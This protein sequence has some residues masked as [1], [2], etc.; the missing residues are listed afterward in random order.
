MM[1]WAV[2]GTVSVAVVL[3]CAPA[4]A[5][6]GT[7]CVVDVHDPAA[8]YEGSH[9]DTAVKFTVTASAGCGG[10]VGY[11]TLHDQGQGWA[12]GSV[13]Y[14][15]VDGV[16]K[17]TGGTSQSV[18][19]WVTADQV[20]EPDELFRVALYGESGVTVG[21]RVA[22]GEVLD[23]ELG[24][25]TQGGRM[26]WYPSHLEL[27]LHLV[28]PARAP[29]AVRFRTVGDTAVGGVHY[30]PVS[31]GVVT[32]GAGQDTAT[33]RVELLGAAAEPG[34]RFFVEL[35]APSA[36]TIDTPRVEV[37]LTPSR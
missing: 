4:V 6:A 37:P 24:V 10:T 17:I 11:R 16:L 28:A 1:R 26:D 3:G 29:V 36:G 27:D 33:A 14:T 31:D 25:K 32:F 21:R 9:A 20:Q 19:V 23:D 13:D 30:V 15:A 5:A 8:V 7:G 2:A 22:T 35:F 34:A 12:T 18:L